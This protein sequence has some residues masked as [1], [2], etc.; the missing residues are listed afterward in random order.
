MSEIPA[1]RAPRVAI[2]NHKGGVG[3]TTLTVNLA[4]AI[5]EAGLKVLLVDT[6]PQCNL[7]T[8]L[9]DD[10]VIDDL[11]DNSDSPDGKTVWS[12]LRPIVEGD[13][14]PKV[15]TTIQIG[16]K[17][18]IL[19]G[20][21]RLAEF[22]AQLPQYWGDC[23]QR[24]PRGFKFTTGL[25]QLV[26]LTTE[27]SPVD[28][29]FY[30]TGPNIGPLNR[31]ILLDCDFFIVPAACDLFSLRAIK[32]LGHTLSSWIEEWKTIEG[33]AP[34]NIPLLEGAPKPLG[35]VPQRFKVY[36]GD[37]ATA[38]AAM[39]PRLEKSM[40]EDVLEVLKRVDET[41]VTAATA[42]L[43]LAEIQDFA[44]LANSAQQDGR[45]LWRA[46]SGGTVELK[47]V[48]KTAFSEFADRVLKR[49]NLRQA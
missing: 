13:G 25:S 8:Y 12:A 29:V 33:L 41:L 6:D 18:S 36:G 14:G 15:V 4:S 43:R 38:Y 40:K 2:F 46:E 31:I 42:P 27:R 47:S 49:V 1:T 35:Y 21:I 20:D 28:I 17:L 11:L 16:D 30:D 44:G 45:A 23:F 7:T 22:E 9:V 10:A 34:D 24:R 5:A 3:K 32:A 37:P 19:P 26:S 39:L 48:A